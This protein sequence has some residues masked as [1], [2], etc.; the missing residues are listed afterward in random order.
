MSTDSIDAA[1][2]RMTL[3][4]QNLTRL[5]P[6]IDVAGLLTGAAIGVLRCAHGPRKATEYFIELAAEM[7]EDPTAIE[8]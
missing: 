5:F 7:S 3:L 4:A 2:T 8:N 1:R 6:A